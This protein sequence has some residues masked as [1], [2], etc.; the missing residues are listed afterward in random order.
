MENREQV[1]ALVK[2]LN[3]TAEELGIQPE[4]KTVPDKQLLHELSEM[5]SGE[6]IN[7]ETARDYFDKKYWHDLGIEEK[8]YSIYEVR[9][10]KTIYKKI[11]VAVPEN[12]SKYDVMDYVGNLSNL[13]N[14]FPDDEDDWNDDDT[15]EFE[16]LTKEEI[17][18]KFGQDD[19]WNYDDFA[20]ED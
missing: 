14:D 16:C 20:D 4:V 8:K 6:E 9:L 13:D 1:I 15:T 5:I 11:N 3:I 10:S 18:A 17:E 19:L 2:A 12:T 7:K